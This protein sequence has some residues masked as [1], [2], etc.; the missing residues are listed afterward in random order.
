MSLV[1]RQLAQ[2]FFADSTLSQVGFADFWRAPECVR[3]QCCVLLGAGKQSAQVLPM[4]ISQNHWEEN[5]FVATSV[6][7][8]YLF[9][10]V[11]I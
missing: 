8:I 2:D 1:R 3:T 6:L 9:F 4:G 11:E 7:F 10:G 5:I